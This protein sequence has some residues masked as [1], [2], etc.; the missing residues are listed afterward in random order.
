MLSKNNACGWKNFLADLVLKFDLSEREAKVFTTKFGNHHR[1][2]S[3]SQTLN[4][5]THL[6]LSKDT[7]VITK[8]DIYDKFANVTD[9]CT[10]LQTERSAKVLHNYLR[11]KYQD[12]LNSYSPAKEGRYYL[13]R[14]IESEAYQELQQINAFVRVR[15][16]QQTGKTLMLKR[17]IGE[18]NRIGYTAIR[19]DFA[20]EELEI[21]DDYSKFI[22]SFCAE[23]CELLKI[24][25]R[26]AEYWSD[27]LGSNQNATRYFE[28]YILLAIEQPLILGLDSLDSVLEHRAVAHNFCR[29]LRAWHDRNGTE[30]QNLRIVI[31]HSTEVYGRSGL[32]INNSPLAGI[33]KVLRLQPFDLS[34]LKIL[35]QRYQLDCELVHLTQLKELTGGH[36]YL[37]KVALEYLAKE[38]NCDRVLDSQSALTWQRFFQLAPT[39]ESP[40]I[41]H[42]R[43]L[44]SNLQQNPEL[45]EAFAE[46]VRAKREIV[47]PSDLGF[48]LL[49]LGL[50]NVSG[51][52]YTPMCELYRKYFLNYLNDLP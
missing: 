9:G 47:L 7:F 44:F 16:S 39:A 2:L 41:N 18:L 1:L 50:V 3:D 4:L 46:V 52:S 6:H 51:N 42:L 25:D 21:F 8:R 29:L 12:W 26:L 34:Q 23:I 19:Y 33:G 36:P 22:T 27:R 30:W 24:E 14:C 15:G 40:L 11:N 17:V 32:D 49:G 28:Q 37:I 48:R 5:I 35:A 45:T 43:Q 10:A 20:L 38:S 13:E 31:V